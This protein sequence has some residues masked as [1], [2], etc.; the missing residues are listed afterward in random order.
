MGKVQKKKKKKTNN[1]APSATHTYIKLTLVSFFL[2]FFLHLPLT[3]MICQAI[4]GPDLEHMRTEPRLF[5]GKAD[6]HLLA[7]VKCHQITGSILI[8]LFVSCHLMRVFLPLPYKYAFYIKY[9]HKYAF[10]MKYYHK[11]A[12]YRK[13]YQP[14]SDA[15]NYYLGSR[16]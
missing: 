13:Y 14:S 10:D 7:Q 3:T 4:A 12:F 9:C 5:P 1:S 2:L 11:Y 15:T 16:I 8:W 6:D